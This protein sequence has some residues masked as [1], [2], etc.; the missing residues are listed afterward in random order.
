MACK[1]LANI[2][3]CDVYPQLISKSILDQINNSFNSFFSKPWLLKEIDSFLNS[4][5]TDY[6]PSSS[7]LQSTFQIDTHSQMISLFLKKHSTQFE[8]V[9]QLIKKIDKTFFINENVQRIALDSQEHRQLIDQLIKDDKCFTLD[10][11][12]NEESK[13]AIVLTSQTKN[14][15]Y[16]GLNLN[17]L[18]TNSLYQLTGKQ[19]EHITNIILNDYLQVIHFIQIEKTSFFLLFSLG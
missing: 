1:L 12:E 11:L 8:R 2:L 7:K 19:Q 16:P 17:V 15:K 5:F 4:F 6:L 10:K 3:I 9:N 14:I 13:L 18:L